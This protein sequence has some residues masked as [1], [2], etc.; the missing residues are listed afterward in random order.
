[1]YGSSLWTTTKSSHISKLS[2]KLLHR[3]SHHFRNTFLW[4]SDSR[5]IRNFRWLELC[6]KCQKY[7]ELLR[8]TQALNCS[9]GFLRKRAQSIDFASYRKARW[10]TSS[11]RQMSNKRI[12]RN[13]R[14]LRKSYNCRI[15]DHCKTLYRLRIF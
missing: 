11:D 14:D 13:S 15:R 4:H 12:S 3:M 8:F 6:W 10:N 5:Q 2:R 9:T 1:M 7:D